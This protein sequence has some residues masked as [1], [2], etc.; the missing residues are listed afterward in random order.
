M[1][2][3]S[4]YF[5][6][7]ALSFFVALSFMFCM[8]IKAEEISTI[9]DAPIVSFDLNNPNAQ[10]QTVIYGDETITFRM[11]EEIPI[12][13]TREVIPIGSFNRYF[14]Y[15]NGDT[16]MQALFSGTVNPYITRFTG[17]SNGTYKSFTGTY[18]RERYG[19]GTYIN[20]N[21]GSGYYTVDYSAL[22][23]GTHSISLFIWI[24]PGTSGGQANATFMTGL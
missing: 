2:M 15:T 1:K 4:S 8:P 5:K 6:A 13:S 7:M 10:E 18:I 17:V 14:S 9:E 11:S 24:T 3:K 22:G 21:T 20:N 16:T 19:T 12:V 23:T